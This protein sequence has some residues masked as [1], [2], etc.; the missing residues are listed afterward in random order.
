MPVLV[1]DNFLS[2]AQVLVEYAAAARP[3]FEGVSD[4][5]YPGSRAPAPQIYCF[6]LR[7]FLGGAIE[8][9]FGLRTTNI[10]GEMSAFSLVTRPPDSLG[11]RQCLPHADNTN[12]RQ[13]ALLHYLCS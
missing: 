6:A 1:V 5:F 7:A 8:Q 13:L 9:T 11:P 2:D 12:P 3:L 4:T 10:T